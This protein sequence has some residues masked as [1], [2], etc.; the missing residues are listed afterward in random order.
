[1]VSNVVY[2]GTTLEAAENLVLRLLL[3]EA[4]PEPQIKGLDAGL[5]AGYIQNLTAAR[6]FQHPVKVVP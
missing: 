6:V 1:M 4:G 3:A 2:Q 5:K